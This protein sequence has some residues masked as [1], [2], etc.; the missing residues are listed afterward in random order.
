MF[1]VFAYAG[2]AAITPLCFTVSFLDADGFASR[3]KWIAFETRQAYQPPS[4]FSDFVFML[5]TQEFE[6]ET[7]LCDRE[8]QWIFIPTQSW[9]YWRADEQSFT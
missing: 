6:W 3:M 1:K 7:F 4:K 5:K 8:C 9:S 2:D